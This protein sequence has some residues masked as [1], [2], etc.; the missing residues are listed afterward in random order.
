MSGWLGLDWGNVPTW[1]GTIVTSSSFTVAAL[2]YRRSVLD[3]ERAQASSIAAWVG[4]K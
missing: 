3:K 2:S 1:I 4:M